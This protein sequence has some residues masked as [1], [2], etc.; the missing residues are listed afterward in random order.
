MVTRKRQTALAVAGLIVSCLVGWGCDDRPPGGPG[1]KLQPVAPPVQANPADSARS[2]QR[3]CWLIALNPEKEEEFLQLHK[4][5]PKAVQAAIR[6]HGIRNFSVHVCKTQEDVFAIRCYEYVGQSHETDLSELSRSPAY[7]QWNDACEE[8]E[9]TLLKF[10]GGGWWA[11]SDEI[12]H[13][14]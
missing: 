3:H 9:V 13:L 2:L 7:K 1:G 10:T 4:E 6:S 8:C 14:D 12:L 5:I 11:P